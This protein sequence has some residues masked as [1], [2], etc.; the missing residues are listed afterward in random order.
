MMNDT[1]INS[2]RDFYE[3]CSGF[4]EYTPGFYEDF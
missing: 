2:N 4:C 1:V 3:I